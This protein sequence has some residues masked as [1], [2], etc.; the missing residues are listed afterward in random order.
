MEW[1]SQI[2]L[3]ALHGSL[4]PQLTDEVLVILRAYLFWM[5]MGCV[6]RHE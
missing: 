6:M 4:F 2:G 5:Y 3:I 1:E